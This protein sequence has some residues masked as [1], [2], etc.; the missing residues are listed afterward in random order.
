MNGI[1]ERS[2]R[3]WK[4]EL[5]QKYLSLNERAEENREFCH[6][7]MAHFLAVARIAQ[8]LNLKEVQ[9]VDEELIYAA[10]LLHDIGRHMQYA[11]GTPHE[12]ASAQLAPEILRDC[13]FNIEETD[14][15]ITAIRKHRNVDSAKEPGLDGLLYRADKLSRTC[16]VCKA[17]KECDWKKGKKNMKNEYLIW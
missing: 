10:A 8:I 5:F 14:T 3:I 1:K 4:H 7:D 9:E 15:I 16:F 17:E 2:N 13:G 6:H 12:A 11:D